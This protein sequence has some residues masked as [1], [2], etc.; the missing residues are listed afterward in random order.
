MSIVVLTLV[1]TL[2]AFVYKKCECGEI[3]Y[4]F[5]GPLEASDNAVLD[6][7][8]VLD[9]LGH[10]DEQVGAG[11]L[12]AEAPNLARLGHVVLVLLVE[13]ASARLELLARRHLALLDVVWQAVRHGHGLHVQTVVLVGRLGET[14]LRGLVDDCLLVGDDRV[15]D[16]D[17][18]AGVILFQILQADLQVELA[19][20]G[21][22]V[23]T[24]LFDDTLKRNK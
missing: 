4:F 12:R 5:G 8:E 19:S 18:N 10:V 17:R 23:L 16:L 2:N 6:L 21:N 3:V 14:H 24:R 13:V 1:Y 22:D 11:A 20:A 9:T 7:V 15:G